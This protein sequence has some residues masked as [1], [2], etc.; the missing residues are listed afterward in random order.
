VGGVASAPPLAWRS[1]WPLAVA[2]AAPVALAL[3]RLLPDHGPALALRLG[4]AAVLVFLLPG[5]A[6]LRAFAWPADLG[7]VVTG[8]FLAS[9]GVIFAA[10]AL[11]LLVN[12]SLAFTIGAVAAVTAAGLV[13]CLLR[14]AR[15]S[16]PDDRLPVV[17]LALAGL[18]LG[19]LTWWS[20]RS[21]TGDGIY[22]LARVRRLDELSSLS[23]LAELDYFTPGALHPGYAFPLWHAAV[24][25]V[26]RLAGVDD[27][28]ALLRLAALLVP[29]V[30]VVAYAAGKAVF[31]ARAG[32]IAVAAGLVG[33]LGFARGGVGVLPLLTLPATGARLLLATAVVAVAFT[34]VAEGDRGALALVAVGALALTAVHPTYSFFVGIALGGFLLAR[35][36]LVRDEAAG[37]RRAA[38]AL[39]AVAVPTALFYVW[40]LPAVRGTAAFTP[41]ST[42][43]GSEIGHYAGYIHG[44]GWSLRLAPE[45]IS[46]GG[47]L[48]VAALASV[49]LA[50]FAARRRWAALVLGG[51][52]AIL[53][54]VLVPVLFKPLSDV[55][56]LSQSRR[57]V[58]FL[59]LPFALAGLAV[60]LGR[61]RL[62]GVALA[63]GLG[64]LLEAIYTAEISYRFEHGGPLWPV[65][66]AFFGGLVALVLGAVWAR[67]GPEATHWAAVAAIALVLPTTVVGLRHLERDAPD[68]Q[69]LSPGLVQAVR[70]EVPTRAVV[71]ADL[72]VGYRLPAYAPVYVVGAPLAHVGNLEANHSAERRRDVRRFFDESTTNAERRLLVRRYR[73]GWLLL[74]RKGWYPKR[75]VASLEPV[76]SDR[77]FVLY[78]VPPA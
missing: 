44:S 19:A 14:P 13:A 59:P 53:V 60:F 27:A 12:G 22:H 57:L 70:T 30:L 52:L 29:L 54:L 38:L 5:G 75:F 41:S 7:L 51:T 20:H 25:L 36:V 28:A 23:S 42:L 4:V 47:A 16:A 64:A 56:S 32:G 17:G 6:L 72:D 9:L 18:V 2:I 63:L 77:T 1:S 10:L 68:P 26:A 43:R 76:Y 8:S 78:R 3:V 62:G 45:T 66:L 24:A 15:P 74:D 67:R 37:I 31:G 50:G 48:V 55:L 35:L 11:T 58:Q 39:G 33:I 21:I 69:A 49:P 61:L 73:A 40:L 46:R 34:F 71:F 65:A